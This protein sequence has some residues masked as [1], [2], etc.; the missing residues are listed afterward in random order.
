[1]REIIG[2][3]T[4]AEVAE[5]KEESAIMNEK[6]ADIVLSD[7][8]SFEIEK[9]AKKV[10]WALTEAEVFAKSVLMLAK[11]IKL[12]TGVEP[13][14]KEL[15]NEY[16][17]EEFGDY[18]YPTE[19]IFQIA[20]GILDGVNMLGYAPFF[21][22]LK[23]REIRLGLR[24]GLDVSIYANEEFH[25]HRQMKQVRLG[26]MDGI[27]VSIYNDPEI[28]YHVMEVLRNLL[29][30]GYNETVRKIISL[31]NWY[32]ILTDD[33]NDWGWFNILYRYIDVNNLPDADVANY[34]IHSEYT[35]DDLAGIAHG[36]H[37]HRN[38]DPE[39]YNIPHLGYYGMRF[40]QDIAESPIG[41]NNYDT[42]KKTADKIRESILDEEDEYD[43]E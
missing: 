17:R 8:L 14:M 12:S 30:L 26:L 18:P 6:V 43:E 2:R 33:G 25:S 27:D 4:R 3:R 24:D 15:Y 13:S 23:M 9:Y 32:D 1:M 42:L 16:I 38:V 34:M 20:Y 19:T 21:P 7:D 41:I 39:L 40:V 29:S 22:S 36:L 31:N 37:Y 5:M 35:V 28:D 11:A 10:E